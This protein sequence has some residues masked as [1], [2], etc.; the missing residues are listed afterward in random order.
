MC[1][2]ANFGILKLIHPSIRG[3]VAASGGS[4]PPGSLP[5]V[6]LDGHQNCS[7][8]TPDRVRR[9][10]PDVRDLASWSGPDEVNVTDNITA[11]SSRCLK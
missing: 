8:P 10:A 1:N 4:G 6:E 11:M 5:P 3:D 7:E 9:A 2:N